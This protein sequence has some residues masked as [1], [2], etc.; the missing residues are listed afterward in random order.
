MNRLQK[1]HEF[2]QSTWLNYLNRPFIQSGELRTH[3]AD[4][5]QGFTANAA[6]FD[7]I[8]TTTDAY[9]DAIW[10]Q[11]RAGVLA[12][13]IYDKLIFYD[14]QIASD[15]MHNVYQESD[16]LE[17]YVSLEL[18]PDLMHD[19]VNTVA[20]VIHLE[21][22]INRAN[23]MVE[24]PATP[25]GIGA[26]KRLTKDGVSLN[27]THVFSVEIYEQVAWAY[28]EGLKIFLDSHSIWRFVPVSVVSFS[29]API[30]DAVDPLLAECGQPKMLG[31]TALAMAKLLYNRC[32]QIF[33]GSDWEKLA[34]QGG[35]VLRPKWSRTTP[36]NPAFP[37]TYYLEALI[38][39]DTVTTFSPASLTAFMDHGRVSQTLTDDLELAQEQADQLERLGIDMER[40]AQNLQEEYLKRSAKQFQLINQHIS[41]KREELEQARQQTAVHPD[42]LS[43]SSTSRPATN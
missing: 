26:V 40:V 41:Q 36:S 42:Q 31:K 39:P 11:I 28:W 13:Q 15:Y 37:E 33:S 9:D 6:S 21:S 24:V 23:A 32:R 35:Y 14:V 5:I 30:D 4:G 3:V 16:G 34:K 8:L 29:L 10:S 12:P 2:G 1:L 27:I 20:E 7:K 17:G 19:T 43:Q 38:G 25:A 18:N 22:V